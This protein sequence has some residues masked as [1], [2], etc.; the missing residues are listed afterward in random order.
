MASL[1]IEGAVYQRD[2]DEFEASRTR[3][4]ATGA[5]CRNDS[6]PML[7]AE[8]ASVKDIQ[9][10]VE[11]ARQKDLQVTVRTGGHN[12]FGSS[13]RE[14]CLLLDMCRFDSID[15]DTTKQT[16]TVGPALLG[17]QL[18]SAAA[19]H[20]LCFPTGHCPGVPLGGFLLGGGYGWFSCHFG[21]AAESILAATI[22]TGAGEVI[23][24]NDENSPDWMWLVRGSASAFPGVIVSFT[25]KLHPLPS[26][27]RSA[28]SIHSVKDF[29]AI[30]SFI[31]AGRL[32]GSLSSKIEMT[33]IL[34][35]TPPPLQELITA[36]KICIYSLSFAADSEDEFDSHLEAA[37]KVPSTAL[38]PMAPPKDATLV[39]LAEAMNPMFAPGFHWA[40]QSFVLDV[41][42]DKLDYGSLG[43]CIDRAAPGLSG[44]AAVVE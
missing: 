23:Q 5:H 34:A 13:L 44:I 17:K 30:V 15:I 41:E 32:D 35:F 2:Q 6:K 38:L 36:D 18:N 20:G 42:E 28:S 26:I 37:K 10:C 4:F 33:A 3:N 24:A 14:D 22:V 21:L 25:L 40:G 27:I 9:A 16:A 1:Q 43:K 29:E 7:I 11:Y 8:V 19:S 31:R 39:E 12:Y